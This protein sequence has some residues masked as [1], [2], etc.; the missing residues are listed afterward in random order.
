MNFDELFPDIR[1]RGETPLRQSQLVML[2]ML[3]ILDYLCTKNNIKYFLVGG[4]LLGAI[5]HKGFIPWDDDLDVGMTR[6]NY[7]KFVKYVVP[8]LPNDIFFQTPETD[9]EY[10]SCRIVESKL[11]DK[12]SSYPLSPE[13]KLSHKWHHG[14]MLDIFIYDRAYLPHNLFIYALNSVLKSLFWKRGVNNDGNVR[15]A[16]V[17][18]KIERFSPFPLVYASIFISDRR[19]V[20]LGANY[21]RQ[22]EIN[23]LVRVP[24]E[25]IEVS[26]PQGWHTCLKRQYGDYM[27]LPPVEKRMG[28]QEDRLP[29]PFSPCDHSEILHWKDL[30]KTKNLIHYEGR[31]FD[32][33]GTSER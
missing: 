29:D 2:R 23:G 7:D 17:L 5:R 11:R 13:K 8:E 32:V 16:K 24:F 18:R 14:L 9:P 12:Y 4:S 1:E 28:H 31:K 21:I 15:R 27:K 26:I 30:K 6:E 19:T 10:P 25:D 22:S 20:R 33:Y 3:K